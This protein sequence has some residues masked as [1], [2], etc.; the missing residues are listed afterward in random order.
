MTPMMVR[1]IRGDRYADAD[2][3]LYHKVVDTVEAYIDKTTGVQ[4]LVQMRGLVEMVRRFGCVDEADILDMRGYKAV[5]N[6]ELLGKVRR[7]ADRLRR[8]ELDAGD[9]QINSARKMLEALKAAGVKLY[10]AS[11]TDQAD[12]AAEA[13]ALG[14]ADLFEGRIFG[15]VGDIKVEAKRVVLEG[16]FAEHGLSGPELATFGD[17]PVELRETRKRGGVAVGVATD[18]RRRFG[19]NLA[20]RARLIR[21]G[22]DLVVAHFT[23]MGRLLE[24]LAVSPRGAE[25]LPRCPGPAGKHG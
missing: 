19:L 8:G 17:G 25:P 12:V 10:L 13:E 18:E 9:F 4:T 21:A 7:R 5:Y 20:K 6:E 14:Y 2:G 22:A 15:A 1:A 11:G 16:I 23:Q 3:A 24:V